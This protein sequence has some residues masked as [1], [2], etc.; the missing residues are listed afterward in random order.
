MEKDSK[1]YDYKFK[2]SK[3]F[4]KDGL[5]SCYVPVWREVLALLATYNV[6]DVLDLGC[7]PGQFA[8][9]AL[10]IKPNLNYTGI[11]FSAEGI[12]RANARGTSGKFYCADITTI[13]TTKYAK[14][15]AVL[16]LEV[17]EHITKDTQ[18]LHS[19]KN[20][21]LICTVPNFSAVS[22]VRYF[23]NIQAVEKRYSKVCTIK[24]IK[25]VPVANKVF[26]LFSGVVC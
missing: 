4:N 20:K 17:L 9:Y 26:F 2:T 5:L 1:Y 6:T 10:H 21:L 16:L 25:A 23:N 13:D 19:I 15:T 3:E 22:H 8:Q 18:L 12:K 11:D 7:G 14:T 24:T